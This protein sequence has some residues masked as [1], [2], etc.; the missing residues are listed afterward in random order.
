MIQLSGGAIEQEVSSLSDAGKTKEQ[1]I[2]ELD[3]AR[4]WIVALELSEIEQ[5]RAETLQSVLLKIAQASNMPG[6]LKNLVRVIHNQLAVLIDTTNFYVALYNPGDDTYT[7]PYAVDEKDA[8]FHDEYLVPQQQKGGLIDYVRRNGE[9]I[10][11]DKDILQRLIAAGEIEQLGPP[12][13]VWLGAP[14]RTSQEVIGVVAVQSYEEQSLYTIRDLDLLTVASEHIASIIKR[15]Q[16]EDALRQRNLFLETLSQLSRDVASTLD[17]RPIMDTVARA[18]GQMINATS[19]YV[20][21]WDEEQGTTTVLA[22]YYSS[23]ASDSERVSDL[24]RTYELDKE[25]GAFAKY[26]RNSV[27]SS[28]HIYNREYGAAERSEKEEY[29]DK[30]TLIVP[31]VAE[32]KT[33]GYIEL[34]E[35]RHKRNF[36][37]EEVEF[38]Q[39]IAHQVSMTINNVQLHKDLQ[40]SEEQYRVLFEN[41]PVGISLSVLDGDV[42]MVNE[43]MKRIIGYSKAELD[44][45]QTGDAYQNPED[46]EHIIAHMER[47][48]Y[49]KDFEVELR[50]KDGSSCCAS[51]S[52]L[53]FSSIGENTVM[54]MVVDLTEH[55][56]AAQQQLELAVERERIQILANFITKASHEFRTPL[57]NINTGAYLLG[58]LADE[59]K[60]RQ[61]IHLIQDQVKS[62]MG[63]V[64]ALVTMTKLDSQNQLA[65]TPI[66]VNELLQVVNEIAE[67]LIKAKKIDLQLILTDEPLIISGNSYYLAHAIDSL[68][69]NAIHY[70]PEGG[71]INLSSSHIVQNAII[72][73][74]DTGCGI[75][76]KD[77][78]HIFERFYRADDAGTTRGFGLGLPIVKSIVELHGGSIETESEE[79]KGSTFRLILPIS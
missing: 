65:M 9:S 15:K 7:F 59:E 19:A 79:G 77:L 48:G 71:S 23:E 63:L 5:K 13:S 62:V 18:A 38:V 12:S 26:L 47:D 76:D 33:L 45:L 44:E 42:F 58:K 8:F 27:H 2:H 25:N 46:R 20:C 52:I 32:N 43:T 34:W 75:G 6:S 51:M 21:D 16:A 72:E 57:S 73:I 60:R 74:R 35:C 66:N 56:R 53:P 55:K 11:V 37:R 40:K 22:E 67:P 69:K 50:Q 31:L 30:S 3:E 1:L 10:R 14:L 49:V 54:T 39:A 36:T 4:K 17:V 68:C 24:G 64:N 78:P 41:V 28:D 61:Y 29:D 70:T